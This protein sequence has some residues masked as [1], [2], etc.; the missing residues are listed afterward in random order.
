VPDRLWAIDNWG[1][2]VRWYGSTEATPSPWAPQQAPQIDASNPERWSRTFDPWGSQLDNE[3]NGG[4]LS[5]TTFSLSL[6]AALI[7]PAVFSPGP[8]SHFAFGDVALDDT[9][10]PPKRPPN[11]KPQQRRTMLP[12]DAEEDAL[13]NCLSTHVC[14]ESAQEQQ[15]RDIA[16]PDQQRDP[17]PAPNP[18]TLS[19]VPY[20]NQHQS[21]E[22]ASPSKRKQESITEDH[23]LSPS[24]SPPSPFKKLRHDVCEK[25]YRDKMNVKFGLLHDRIPTIRSHITKGLISP[26]ES[27]GGEKEAGDGNGECKGDNLK[28]LK[29]T[30]KSD[31][32]TILSKALEYISHLETRNKRLASEDTVLRTRVDAFEKLARAGALGCR[33]EVVCSRGHKAVPC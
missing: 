33:K 12:S 18:Q 11:P 1:E 8:Y 15:L 10:L 17:S 13:P 28:G 6:I 30:T 5:E 19:Q 14:L 9:I 7:D 16:M 23:P 22:Q 27:T 4:V 24:A 29:T 26:P 2:S 31:K 25:R 20:P 21:P 32:G 3:D